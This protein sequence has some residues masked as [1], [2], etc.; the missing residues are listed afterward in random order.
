MRAL[1]L[2]FVVAALLASAGGTIVWSDG[3]HVADGDT[4]V[5]GN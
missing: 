1:V 2:S 4:V 5:W 3:A